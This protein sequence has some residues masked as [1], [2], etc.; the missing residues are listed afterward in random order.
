[1]SCG[2]VA[3]S[4]LAGSLLLSVA[5]VAQKPDLSGVEIMTRPAAG[6]IYM[7]EATG[8]VAGNIAVSV[9]A[10]GI[11][12][13]DDQWAE[14]TEPISK[15]LR[16]IDSGRLRF[17]INTHHHDD[18]SD[19]NAQLVAANDALIVAHEKARKRLLAKDSEHW[20]VITFDSVLSLH[21]NGEEVRALAIPGGHT[22]N[23]IV[24]F[25]TQSKV[26]HM[27][28]L[29]NSGTSSFPVVDFD[30]GGNALT[31][32]EN[33]KTLLPLIP[34]DAVVI[35]GH[36]PLTDKAELRELRDMLEETIALVRGHKDKGRNVE[37]IIEIG[38]GPE[39]E[40]WGYGYMPEEGWIEAIFRSLD[41]ASQD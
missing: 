27:G 9:G 10:D 41:E 23:D 6:S 14:L 39:Y 8:D 38:L 5:G 33:V 36:G 18:H 3:T 12:I 7:L 25:F 24:V 15:A 32:L 26:V 37:E 1:M 31:T 17:I 40:D 29:F 20:P 2:P 35:P 19:G 16:A 13:V 34:D 4:A 28:D 22:D 11:L 30:A 21:F